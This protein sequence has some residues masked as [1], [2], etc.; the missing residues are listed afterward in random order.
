MAKLWHIF[1][2]FVV[3]QWIQSQQKKQLLL[4]KDQLYREKRAII[5]GF[6]YEC[7][8]TR[9]YGCPGR[10]KVNEDRTDLMNIK[11]NYIKCDHP[12]NDNIEKVK[13]KAR[14]NKFASESTENTCQV[15]ARFATS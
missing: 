10:V 4:F 6:T 8:Y 7:V 14:L 12:P 13:F 3:L 15:I 2:I 1:I 11:E 5:G 9:D